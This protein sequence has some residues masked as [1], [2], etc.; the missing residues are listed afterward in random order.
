MAAAR[1]GSPLPTCTQICPARE[2]PTHAC[3]SKHTNAL[4]LARGARSYWQLNDIWAGASW[5]S[6]DYEGRWKPLHYGAKRLF[7][8]L[9]LSIAENEE[10]ELEVG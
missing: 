9:A 4:S 10:G 6:V 3:T 1:A 5:S 8:P 7:A 2:Y